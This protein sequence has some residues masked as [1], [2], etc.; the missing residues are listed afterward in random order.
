MLARLTALVAL[1][2]GCGAAEPPLGPHA[3]G[4]DAVD[5]EL[6]GGTRLALELYYPADPADTGAPDYLLTPALQAGMSQHLGIPTLAL[7]L[8]E[9]TRGRRGVAPV[10]GPHPLVIFQHGYLSFARQNTKQLEHLASHGIVVASVSHPGDSLATEYTNATVVPFDPADPA[11][12]AL[13][14]YDGPAM[15]RYATTLA[16]RFE[17]LRAAET[18]A[19]WLRARDQ[20]QAT[21]ALAPTADVAQRWVQHTVELLQALDRYPEPHPVLATVDRSRVGLMG[22]SLGGA[23]SVASAQRLAAEGRPVQAVVNLDGPPLVWESEGLDVGAPALFLHGHETVLSGVPVS[24]QGLNSRL[25]RTGGGWV[26]EC[27][28]AGHDNFTD[29]TYVPLYGLL[30]P[31][32]MGSVDGAAFGQWMNE[33][34]A[35]FFAVQLS[36]ESA[37]PPSHDGVTLSVHTP[38]RARPARRSTAAGPPPG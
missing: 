4:R 31:D 22:H 28:G 18:D 13:S 3:I 38:A 33:L 2:T 30:R 6:A 34:T 11:F 12:M 37:A 27:T 26:A 14:A 7:P 20:L 10:P 9:T 32:A 5:V 19:Q 23:V 16:D 36:G 21:G 17:G 24:N 8:S 25:V 29:L 1:L 15:K 35:H